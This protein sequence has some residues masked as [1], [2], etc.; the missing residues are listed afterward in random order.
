META[1]RITVDFKNLP[2]ELSTAAQFL[3]EHVK[4]HVKTRGNEIQL[5]EA[6]HK[7]VRLLLH[8]YLHHKGIN[9]YRV[10]SQSGMF[11]IAAIPPVAPSRPTAGAPPPASSTLPYLFPS[12]PVLAPREKKSTAKKKQQATRKS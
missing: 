4:G 12:A 11:A 3:K 10:L 9:G 5:D 1:N 8:K 6:R 2:G 7:E